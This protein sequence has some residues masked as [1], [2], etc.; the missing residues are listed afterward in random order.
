[1][2]LARLKTQF[3]IICAVLLTA[4][5]SKDDDCMKTIT[6]PQYY[7]VGNQFYSYDTE[8][9]VPC[10]FPDAGDPQQIAPQVLE[11]FTFEVLSFVFIPDTG[12][13][14]NRLQ[15]EI[16]LNNPKS[17]V[18]TGVPVITLNIDG[19]E[20]TTTLANKATVPCYD[21]EANGSCIMTYDQESSL[22]LK[23]IENIQIINV[24]YY[25]T[26]GK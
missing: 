7:V 25:L 17:M 5:G 3:I 6:I 8:M 10:D 13:N 1:M 12:K 14:T 26:S 23:L 18:V 11:G 2:K 19:L 9:E 16:K 15:F 21:I 20:S 24:E 4:C 22:D